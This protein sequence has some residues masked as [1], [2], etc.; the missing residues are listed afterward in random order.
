M[1]SSGKTTIPRNAQWQIRPASAADAAWWSRWDDLNAEGHDS[2]PLLASDMVRLLCK[3]F[4]AAPLT[5]AALAD[6]QRTYLQTILSAGGFGK[7]SLFNP[8]QAP[9]GPLVCC[10]SGEDFSA[11]LQR[12]TRRLPRLGLALDYPTHDP[13]CAPA[14]TAPAA[15]HR[16]LWGTTISVSCQGTFED[17]WNARSKELRHNVRRYFRRIDEEHGGAWRLVRHDTPEAV[18]AAVAR[19]GELESRGWKA[20]EGTALHPTNVQGRFYGELLAAFAVRGCA[21]VYEFY[22]GEAVAASRLLISGPTMYVILKTTYDE[23]LG[24]VAPGRL[25]LHT[26]LK[27]LFAAPTRRAVEFYTRANNDTLAWATDQ[28]DIATVTVYRNRLVAGLANL[29]RQRRARN[30]RAATPAPASAS[31][32][33]SA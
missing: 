4:A 25:L 12:L 8:S 6:S 13:S 20:K 21:H 2:H 28:R 30:A 18:A 17:Y 31:D 10:R 14:V 5:L 19:Y 15:T 27:E 23:S 9:V 32:A 16:T 3:H 33:S 29:Q 22:V 7:W 24:R 11:H 26:I 1:S